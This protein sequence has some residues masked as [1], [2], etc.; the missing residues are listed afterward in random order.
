M[1]DGLS[2][3]SHFVALF[4]EFLGGA[5]QH[6][7]RSEVHW[8]N[9]MGSWQEVLHGVSGLSWTHAQAVTDWE[10]SDVWLVELVDQFHVREDVCVSGMVD[11]KIVTW[12][13][14]NKSACVSSSYLNTLWSDTC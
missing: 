6:W 14:K 1:N 4:F 8:N 9:K 2:S 5:G 10:A 13:L 7:E 11:S 12:D 3:N